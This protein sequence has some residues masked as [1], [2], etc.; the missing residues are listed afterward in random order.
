MPPPHVPDTTIHD[1]L[2]NA[3]SFELFASYELESEDSELLQ[4]LISEW[5]SQYL[6]PNDAR[7]IE[8]SDEA[9]NTCVLRRRWF[10]SPCKLSTQFCRPALSGSG[11]ETERTGGQAGKSVLH[12]AS[13]L[14][15]QAA[16]PVSEEIGAFEFV[17]EGAFAVT[18]RK[19]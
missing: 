16:T 3:F 12:M 14:H 8:K 9:T 18:T 17:V 7:L 13:T 6:R 15:V 5:R 2:Y 1:S 10:S 11:S 4:K 19:R